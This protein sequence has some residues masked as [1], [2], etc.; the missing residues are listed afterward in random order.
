MLLRDHGTLTPVAFCP[1]AL[2]GCDGSRVDY[3]PLQRSACDYAE[4]SLSLCICHCLPRGATPILTHPRYRSLPPGKVLAHLESTWLGIQVTY[5][6]I[7]VFSCQCPV[8]GARYFGEARK[9]T[10]H[11]Y[12]TLTPEIAGCF[13]LEHLHNFMCFDAFNLSAV[14]NDYLFLH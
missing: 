12:W 7:C 3:F 2:I 13:P 11:Y 9:S 8:K 1:A 6:L 14:K 10:L 4:V 5:L